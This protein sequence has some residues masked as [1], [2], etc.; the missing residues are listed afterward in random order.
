[1][2]EKEAE[3]CQASV[4]FGSVFWV[5]LEGGYT[6]NKPM[7]MRFLWVFIFPPQLVAATAV[8]SSTC[9]QMP[10]SNFNYTRA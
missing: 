1:M 6:A 7:F 10:Q 8:L 2:S 9:S 4:L 3:G 5:G